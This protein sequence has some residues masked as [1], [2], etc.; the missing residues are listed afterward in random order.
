M[1]LAEQTYADAEKRFGT[2]ASAV[3]EQIQPGQ[4]P[5]RFLDGFQ[6]A[7]L[8]GK[9]GNSEAL[10][11]SSTAA[12][13]TAEQQQ[14]AYDLGSR[15]SDSQRAVSYANGGQ[16]GQAIENQGHGGIIKYNNI[17]VRTW[18][19]EQVNH[20]PDLI[21]TSASK[22][23][24]ARQAFELRNQIRNEAREMME[25]LELRKQLDQQR[26]NITFEELVESKMRRKGMTK[27][28]AIWDIYVTATKTNEKVNHELGLGGNER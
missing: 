24:R 26:P 3:L 12:Y 28:E 6:N 2:N 16:I 18:Y 5:R 10:E 8:A 17:D 22:E 9:M 15:A 14:L 23:Q 20:I 4:D 1:I 21:D 13:L 27:E 11:N 7:Y 19:I 25:D